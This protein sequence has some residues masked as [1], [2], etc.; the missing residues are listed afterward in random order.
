MQREG[1]AAAAA[2]NCSSMIVPSWWLAIP[3]AVAALS[4]G[5]APAGG[6]HRADWAESAPLH[7]PGELL[8][9]LH[10]VATPGTPSQKTVV[11]L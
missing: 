7:L 3:G 11:Q 4:V 10:T 5:G 1:Q 8:G 2:T 6:W 9:V